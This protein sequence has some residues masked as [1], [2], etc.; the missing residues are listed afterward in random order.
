MLWIL[1]LLFITVAGVA[2]IITNQLSS[3]TWWIAVITVASLLG[4]AIGLVSLQSPESMYR[5]P[6]ILNDKSTTIF[7]DDFVQDGNTVIIDG[8]ATES[9]KLLSFDFAVYHDETLVIQ[10]TGNT[11]DYQFN[12]YGPPKQKVIEVR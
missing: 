4:F 1:A 3:K 8:Y 7:F 9:L 12:K 10:L 11:F 5:A 6:V 2:S